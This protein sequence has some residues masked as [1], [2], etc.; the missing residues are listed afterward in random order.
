MFVFTLLHA[1][2]HPSPDLS[3]SSV[4]PVASMWLSVFLL[5]SERHPPWLLPKLKAVLILIQVLGRVHY[6]HLQLIVR[7]EIHDG[8]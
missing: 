1:S 4:L 5:W 7:L 6:S 2:P 3:G 8:N